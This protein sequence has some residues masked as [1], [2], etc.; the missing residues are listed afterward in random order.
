M[1]SAENGYTKAKHISWHSFRSG[2]SE[3][4]TVRLTKVEIHEGV[5]STSPGC[6]APQLN[7]KEALSL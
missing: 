2:G 6:L 3:F 5:L 4:A 1:K 7:K